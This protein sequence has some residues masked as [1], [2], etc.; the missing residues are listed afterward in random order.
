[1]ETSIRKL[2]KV[3][4]EFKEIVCSPKERLGSFV[5]YLGWPPRKAI[6]EIGVKPVTVSDNVRRQKRK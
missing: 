1:M 6:V 4:I 5:I 3:N 2:K